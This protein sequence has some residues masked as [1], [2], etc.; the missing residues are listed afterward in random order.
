MDYRS[1]IYRIIESNSPW[2]GSAKNTDAYIQ[3]N[4]ECILNLM[5]SFLKEAVSSVEKWPE[6]KQ[7][8]GKEM[9]PLYSAGMYAQYDIDKKIHENNLSEILS[10]G[11]R[12]L[13]GK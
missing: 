4:V 12:I 6:P 3:Q 10:N 2:R 7:G 1:E 9:G 5:Q 13:K 11:E 8:A